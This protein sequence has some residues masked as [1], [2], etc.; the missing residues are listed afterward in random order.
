MDEVAQAAQ[1]LGPGALVA[2][3]YIWAAYHLVPVHPDDGPLL[4]FQ[5]KGA[6][7]VDGMLPFGLRSAPK[8]F[9]AVA[10]ALEWMVQQKGVTAVAHYLDDVVV[11]GPPESPVCGE[12]LA[13]I[14]QT[15]E[16]LGFPLAMDKLE[17]LVTRMAFLGIEIDS[18]GSLWQ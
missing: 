6:H 12:H 14:Q 9:T 16:E 17:G 2:K 13:V 8:L 15:C 5:W 7:Y 11:L 4:G 10:D 1:A 18:S 3:L